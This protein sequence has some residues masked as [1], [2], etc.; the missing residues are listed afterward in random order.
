MRNSGEY[1]RGVLTVNEEMVAYE[2]RA[3]KIFYKRYYLI[4]YEGK[5]G[6]K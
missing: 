5:F 3:Y 2:D 4:A 1:E 6:G